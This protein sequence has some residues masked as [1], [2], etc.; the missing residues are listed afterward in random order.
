MQC[1]IIV[2]CVAGE[3]YRA[4]WVNPGEN[5]ETAL[6]AFLQSLK[7]EGISTRHIEHSNFTW[8]KRP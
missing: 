3:P 8:E 1:S 7:E 6:Q 5:E 4:R 2:A